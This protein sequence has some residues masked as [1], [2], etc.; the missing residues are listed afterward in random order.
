MPSVSWISPPAPL[1]IF[2]RSSNIDG[3]QQ[4][5]PD[6]R[7]SG[8]RLVRLGLLDDVR[9]LADARDDRLCSSVTMPYLS[10]SCF[11]TVLHAEHAAAVS[12]EDIDHLLQTGHP[13]IDQIVR[14][15][16]HEGRIADHRPRAQHR[17]TQAQR[18]RLAYVH[19]RGPARQN[20]AQRL[21]QLLFAL[22]LQHGLEFRIAVEVIL[23]GALGASGDEH[24]RVGARGQAPRRPRTGSA[25]CRRSAASPWGLP[26]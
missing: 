21:E 10:V 15:M 16:H 2:A 4:V 24:Q 5:A 22:L 9:H 25:A 18:R 19:A 1:P 12:G 3:G 20:A 8:C 14:E 23:D 17:V 13:R 11:G 26:W 6:H 7:Q